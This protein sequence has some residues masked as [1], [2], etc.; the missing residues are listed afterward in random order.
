MAEESYPGKIYRLR[1]SSPMPVAGG[2]GAS[3][4][5]HTFGAEVNDLIM[6]ECT[7]SLPGSEEFRGQ[8]GNL[9][10]ANFSRLGDVDGHFQG[11]VVFAPHYIEEE[12]L[13]FNF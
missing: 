10:S 11:R 1:A 7:R 9:I 8:G 13:Q 2:G 3:F 5:L 12:A 4:V 6:Y